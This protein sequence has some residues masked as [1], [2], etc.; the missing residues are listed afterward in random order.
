MRLDFLITWYFKNL[1]NLLFPDHKIQ[2]IS[3]TNI[4]PFI[5][6]L[7]CTVDSRKRKNLCLQGTDSLDQQAVLNLGELLSPSKHLPNMWRPSSLSQIGG[8]DTDKAHDSPPKYRSIQSKVSNSTEAEKPCSRYSSHSKL[9]LMVY[10]IFY[11][12]ERFP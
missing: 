11:K 4:Y 10:K 3:S 5:P 2:F 1:G 7:S 9:F 8:G 6:R 12:K